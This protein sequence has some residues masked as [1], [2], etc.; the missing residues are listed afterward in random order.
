MVVVN[1]SPFRSFMRSLA[2][3]FFIFAVLAAVPLFAQEQATETVPLRLEDASAN[4]YLARIGYNDPEQLKEALDRVQSF[5]EE[6]AGEGPSSP[7][8]IVVHGPEVE[9]FAK[10]NYG[11]YKTIVDKAAQLAAFGILDISVCE[12]R[13]GFDDIEMSEVYPFVSTV[14]FGPAEE[15]RLITKEKYIY[16]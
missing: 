8:S 13:L 15:D 12:T 11:E 5:Y 3:T 9:V 6:N 2:L 16:F 1:P 14:P 4:G 7:I 10:G